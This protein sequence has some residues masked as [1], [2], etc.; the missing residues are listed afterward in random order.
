MAPKKNYTKEQ[1]AKAIEEV[2]R[3]EKISV[4]ATKYAVPRITLRNKITGKSPIDCNLGP[5]TVLAY[6]EERLLVRW[7]KF[8]AEKHFPVTK[9]QLLDS[10]QKI[11][12][13]KDLDS[14][15]FT[16]NRPGKKWFSAFLNRHP[17]VSERT[18]QNL[19]KAREEVTEDDILGWFHVIKGY[20]EKNGLLEAI[21]DP[22]RIFN[23]D[24]SAF[25]LQPKA[26]RVIV[27]KGEK[28][29]YAASGDEKENLTVLITG[30]AAG[31][32]APPM[33]VYAYERLPAVIA[34]SVPKDWCIGRSDSGWMCAKT[35]YEYITNVFNPWIEKNN[36]PKPV[37]L[38][39]DGH[40]SHMTLH[41]SNFCKD[42]GIEVISLYPNSTHL[43]QPM[44]V[45]VFRPLK[46]SWKNQVKSWK[47][48][49]PKQVLK[50]EHFAPNFEAA[51]RNLE[52]DTIKNGFRK[53]GLF[54]FG[55]EYVDMNKI[56]SHNRATVSISALG[57]KIDSTKQFMNTL[58]SEIRN[59]FTDEKLNLFTT[60]YYTPRA[61]VEDLLPNEDLSLYTIWAKSK[62]YLAEHSS[63][64]TTIAEQSIQD[65]DSPE[66]EH[67]RE[68][69]I[70]APKTPEAY[71]SENPDSSFPEHTVDVADR[72]SNKTPETLTTDMQ[73]SEYQPSTSQV[74]T[75]LN[76]T[77]GDGG[78]PDLQE[79]DIETLFFQSTLPSVTDVTK[80][81][82][83]DIPC[84]AMNSTPKKI[85]TF[86]SS[87][88]TAK[89][90]HSNAQ[91]LIEGTIE[92][93]TELSNM[94]SNDILCS[95]M[96]TPDKVQTSESNDTI[97]KPLPP[98]PQNL[99]EENIPSPFKRALF[100]PEPDP[101]KRRTKE[102]I[103]SAITGET[104][105]A[106]M[107]KKENEKKQKEEEKNKRMKERQEKQ[108]MKKKMAEE[109]KVLNKKNI[110]KTVTKKR[111]RIESSISSEE[112]ND[113]H[114]PYQ[115]SDQDLELSEED[116]INQPKRRTESTDS[117]ENIPLK[118]ISLQLLRKNTYVIIKYEGEY[119]PGL[120]K[121]IDNNIYEI[122]TM[123]ISKGNTFR[124]PDTPDQIWYNKEAIIEKIQ[125]P[126]VINKRGF[127][128]VPEMQKY[129]PFIC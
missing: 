17:D 31:I 47:R 26:G 73:E 39:L 7:I 35:F 71:V 101:K 78:N 23:G 46:L 25:Y 114:I 102:R 19:S 110:A 79:K 80:T 117:D 86:K 53:S 99:M 45:A 61:N 82:S 97:A 57:K 108:L 129:L 63:Q 20:L 87:D 118:N 74:C 55:P 59:L 88:T 37:I 29:V 113:I 6:E 70:L 123:V 40:R 89:S 24:E 122:S 50:R 125:Q 33:I 65:S 3:G 127:F 16:N 77:D 13:E 2:R 120:I 83:K 8:M 67:A 58:E 9:D 109:K 75:D 56:S 94:V 104:W 90:L 32:L 51:L 15:P 92:S 1:M 106:Y 41:L 52:T 4:A 95:A 76:A 128:K 81:A 124:W 126:Q 112:E 10:V 43:L 103:P 27:R 21:N 68:S 69:E 96:C 60:M 14:C 64:T 5:A 54:P 22:Q 38:F 18:A 72:I 34:N 105:R 11:I 119:F 44:D 98:K 111:K 100:W 91:H 121:N 116:Q 85:Q 62:H 115:E 36:I 42:N 107:T 30:N 66:P 93:I 28:N 84:K 49:N 48:E 12:S